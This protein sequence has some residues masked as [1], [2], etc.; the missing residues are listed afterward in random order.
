MICK[1]NIKE[2]ANHLL[3]V[4]RGGVLRF[5]HHVFVLI[6]HVVPLCSIDSAKITSQRSDIKGN[7][8]V[9]LS[10]KNSA[11]DGWPSQ[12]PTAFLSEAPAVTHRLQ[13]PKDTVRTTVHVCV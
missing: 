1:G 13:P 3:Y 6:I 4:V 12:I 7:Y 8:A 2:N 10:R 9:S 5:P 11:E